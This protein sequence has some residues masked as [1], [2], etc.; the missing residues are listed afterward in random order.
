[1]TRHS[2]KE[3]EDISI[4][5]IEMAEVNGTV[6]NAEEDKAADTGMC[7]SSVL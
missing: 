7:K 3:R 5:D 2:E 6:A 1:M 4:S